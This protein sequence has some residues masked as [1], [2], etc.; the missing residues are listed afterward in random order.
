MH[1]K[2]EMY[3]KRIQMGIKNIVVKA[4]IEHRLFII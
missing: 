1:R 2:Q 3:Q 4:G